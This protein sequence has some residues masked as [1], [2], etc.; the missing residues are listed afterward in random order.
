MK[1]GHTT[2]DPTDMKKVIKEYYEEVYSHRSITQMKQNDSLKAKIFQNSSKEKYIIWPV[3]IKCID[4]TITNISKQ[5]SPDADGF[6]SE[7]YQT[8]QEEN[9]INSVQS[10]PEIEAEEAVTHSM[11]PALHKYEN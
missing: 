1:K 10:F 11:R 3:C 2:T 4:S 9:S 8:F 7:C 6:T 5:K